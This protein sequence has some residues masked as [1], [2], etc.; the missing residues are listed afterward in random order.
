MNNGM[1]PIPTDYLK[2]T[3]LSNVKCS[4]DDG[5]LIDEVNKLYPVYAVEDFNHYNP[6]YYTTENIRYISNKVTELLRGVHPDKK[7]IIVS[8]KQILSVMQSIFEN[9]PRVSNLVKL[10]M[11]IAYI[12]NYI[13][14]EYEVIE[15]NDDLNIEVI[16]YTG[17][18]GIRKVSSI[19]LNHKRPTP[20][21]FNMNY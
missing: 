10:N 3:P 6:Y 11:V 21:I 15:Q 9:N 14:N 2:Y 13:K 5:K 12:A 20:F 7:N 19:K 17:E 16:K 1:D 18:Y 4:V 8:D